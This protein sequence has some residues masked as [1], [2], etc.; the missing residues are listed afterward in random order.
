[1]TDFAVGLVEER[2]DSGGSR[3]SESSLE[4]WRRVIVSLYAWN[5]EVNVL[6]VDYT[7]ELV[8]CV[9]WH[10]FTMF[11]RNK[12][13]FHYVCACVELLLE[14]VEQPYLLAVDQL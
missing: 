10:N 5:V 2:A 11:C 6:L 12:L 8:V 13:F 3:F 1:M 4:R 14:T 9:E 7:I